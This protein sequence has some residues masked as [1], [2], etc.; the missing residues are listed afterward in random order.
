MLFLSDG[1]AHNKPDIHIKTDIGKD[2]F[3]TETH[4]LFILF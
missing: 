2:E 4:H 3:G 1:Q